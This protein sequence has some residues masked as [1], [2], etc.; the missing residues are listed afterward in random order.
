[1]FRR[2]VDGEPMRFNVF[3]LWGSGNVVTERDLIPTGE[4]TAYSMWDGHPLFGPSTE[5]LEKVPILLD[6]IPL[7]EMLDRY[8]FLTGNDCLV[9]TGDEVLGIE[10]ESSCDNLVEV[11]GERE[12]ESCLESCPGWPRAVSD[13]IAN[14]R[15]CEEEPVCNR[16]D[17][18]RM[19]ATT[20][21]TAE[22][23]TH[24]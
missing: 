19:H 12:R 14:I 23:T 21:T 20:E 22:T 11:C 3:G 9:W 6:D 5:S 4:N 2:E 18:E 7:F 8:S 15:T 16:E 24:P 1:V 17:W 10:C 13:C